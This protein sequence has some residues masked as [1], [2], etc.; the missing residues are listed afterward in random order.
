MLF[1][2][3][4]ISLESF[5]PLKMIQIRLE[6]PGRLSSINSSATTNI[7]TLAVLLIEQYDIFV[8]EM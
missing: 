6:Q 1:L 3:L 2:L 5:Y 8:N 4:L 7:C